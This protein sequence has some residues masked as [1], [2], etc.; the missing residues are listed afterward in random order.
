MPV[1]RKSRGRSKGGKG[2]SALV[3]CSGCGELVPRDKAKR[4]S[5]RVSMVDYALAK[6][7]RQKGA[8]IAAPVDTK[9]YCVSCAV[10]HGV[11]KVRAKNERKRRRGKRY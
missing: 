2:K 7:L 10:H 4:V 3:Q 11:V 9:Y 5:K 1:K 6:E 8:Y